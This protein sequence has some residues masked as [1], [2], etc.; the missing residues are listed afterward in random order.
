[1]LGHYIIT[2]YMIYFK[3]LK[4]KSKVHCLLLPTDGSAIIVRP[5]SKSKSKPLSHQ[6]PKLNTKTD[7][8]IGLTLK[9][10]G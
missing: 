2:Y 7:L 4:Y 3:V 1:M 9:S 5:W 10:H 8:D 6:S